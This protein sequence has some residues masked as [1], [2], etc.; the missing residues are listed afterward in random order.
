MLETLI[1]VISFLYLPFATHALIKYYLVQ[2]A[3]VK[4]LI[5]RPTGKKIIYRPSPTTIKRIF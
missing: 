5:S 2:Q 4:E 3:I 1:G